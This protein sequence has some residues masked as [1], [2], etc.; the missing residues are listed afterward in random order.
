ME[1]LIS[2]AISAVVII[3]G[4]IIVLNG[5]KHIS[6]RSEIKSIIDSIRDLVTENRNQFIRHWME[7]KVENDI[8]NRVYFK[9]S[10]YYLDTMKTYASILE[11]YKI[12][13]VSTL[14]IR[15][16]NKFL[17]DTPTRDVRS[18][19]VMFR[20]FVEHKIKGGNEHINQLIK[21]LYTEHQNKFKPTVVP[22]LT[23]F[24]WPL[25]VLAL[26]LLSF[27]IYA[28]YKSTI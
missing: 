4:W 13:T 15:Q 10:L 11:T 12:D 28:I 25:I 26:L 9:Q 1:K 27:V 6:T 21:C 24:K 20:S 8:E 22:A 16:M 14:W 18:D 5:A 17:T 2:P 7:Y 19:P 23:S 3:V